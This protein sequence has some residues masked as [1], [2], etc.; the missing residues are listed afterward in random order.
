MPG[1]PDGV[2]VDIDNDPPVN[3]S[4]RTAFVTDLR[5][6]GVDNSNDG[7]IWSDAFGLPMLVAREGMHPPGTPSGSRF[8]Y[9]G[10][11]AI[12]SPGQIAFQASVENEL[13]SDQSIWLADSTSLTMI[14]RT[15]EPA[16][17]TSSGVNF[18]WVGWHQAAAALNSAGQV[19]F[20]ATLSGIGVD[21]T[22]DNGIWSGTV[23]SL[24][25]VA[26]AGDDAPGTPAGTKFGQLE[27]PLLNSASHAAFLAGLNGVGVN[28]SND[29][30]IWS[31]GSGSLSMVA[32]EGTHAP[33]VPEGVNFGEMSYVHLVL[34]SAGQ[35]AFATHLNRNGVGGVGGYGIWAE[36]R[37]GILRLVV[38]E[39]DQLEVAPGDYRTV[40]NIDFICCTSSDEGHFNAF[41]NRGQ[42]AF[43]ADFYDGT[44]GIFVSSVAAV[45]EPNPLLLAA[46]AIV[47]PLSRLRR[48]RPER[49]S[50][51]RLR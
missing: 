24:R 13:F 33:G 29:L 22:N 27:D 51:N 40:R 9:F 37:S 43:R 50:R 45:P 10:H 31:E 39:E 2:T 25:V 26:R 49:A 20:S 7:A 42:L 3:S 36:D 46:A 21:H 16:P 14:A 11:P 19:A 48:V 5:G 6:N 8:G 17:S 18:G 15:G 4:G 34:N 44:S 23:G 30:S 32:R 35:V 28:T 12:N 38:V 1:A 41:N 47:G